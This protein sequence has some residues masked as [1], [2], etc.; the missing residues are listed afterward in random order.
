MLLTVPFFIAVNY[1]G[2]TYETIANKILEKA[3]KI[4]S[5]KRFVQELVFCLPN[6]KASKK[7]L[8]F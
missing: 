6:F 8:L 2:K 3:M 1:V 7:L 4:S 5:L